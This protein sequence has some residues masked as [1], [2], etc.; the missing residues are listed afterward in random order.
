MSNIVRLVRILVLS[1]TLCATGTFAALATGAA[2][3]AADAAYKAVIDNIVVPF[4][5][6]IQDANWRWETVEERKE[7]GDTNLIDR[8]ISEVL[9]H[10]ANVRGTLEYE[11]FFQVCNLADNLHYLS[12]DL[13]TYQFMLMGWFG[14]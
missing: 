10:E 5:T 13:Y 1:L 8:V 2:G 4:D 11:A 9:V 3:D 7:M 6:I 14:F 12:Q